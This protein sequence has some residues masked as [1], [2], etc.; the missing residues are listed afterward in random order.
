MSKI[1]QPYQSAFINI[2]IYNDWKG[3]AKKL[4]R[5]PRADEKG[6]IIPKMTSNSSR[7]ELSDVCSVKGNI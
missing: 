1:K 6:E 3:N 4:F 2:E 7:R 5:M